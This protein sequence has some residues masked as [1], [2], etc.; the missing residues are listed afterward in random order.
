MK[1]SEVL[2]N[3]KK[4]IERPECWW[5][6]PDGTRDQPDGTNCAV[7]A[8]QA[9]CRNQRVRASKTYRAVRELLRQAIGLDPWDLIPYWND[10]STH[11]EVL[12][13]FDR[14]IALAEAEELAPPP[15]GEGKGGQGE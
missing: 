2:R 6:D 13:A 3:A 8:I 5:A 4:L 14:A 10:R 7:Q 12:A 15:D 1:P 9:A 11:A